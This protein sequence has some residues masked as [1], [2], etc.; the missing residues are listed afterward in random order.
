MNLNG[1]KVGEFFNWFCDAN[2][3][4]NVESVLKLVLTDPMTIV[5]F[6]SFTHINRLD[7]LEYEAII[8]RDAMASYVYAQQV[9]N[10][11]FTAGEAEILKNPTVAAQYAVAILGERWPEA[12]SS[13]FSESA[14]AFFYAQRFNIQSIEVENALSGDGKICFMYLKMLY[15]KLGTDALKL[16]SKKVFYAAEEKLL[17]LKKSNK[18]EEYVRII[19]GRLPEGLHNRLILEG[20]KWYV[21]FLKECEVNAR[22]YLET[23]NSEDRNSLVA[24][25]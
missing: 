4:E 9:I 16:V 22:R 18:I 5:Q 6:A 12:E 2:P 20:N 17:K 23:L 8:S 3:S 11:R 25:I 10:Q 13:I 24:Q 15:D 19:G 14:S 21:G 7:F 1:R